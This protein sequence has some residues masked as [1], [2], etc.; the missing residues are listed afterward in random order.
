MTS[1]VT[2]T[3]RLFFGRSSTLSFGQARE[4]ENQALREQEQEEARRAR[5]IAEQGAATRRRPGGAAAQ[6][7]AR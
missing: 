4:A 6:G 1:E 5:E 7:P 3:L 2:S